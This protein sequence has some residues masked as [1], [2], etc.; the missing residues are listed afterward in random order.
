METAWPM[1][2]QRRDVEF[3]LTDLPGKDTV[4]YKLNEKVVE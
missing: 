4:R 3:E 1:R 2:T